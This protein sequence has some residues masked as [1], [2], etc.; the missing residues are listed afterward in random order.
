MRELVLHQTQVHLE[1]HIRR[2]D[3]LSHLA[4]SP[5][6]SASN[7]SSSGGGCGLAHL[8]LQPLGR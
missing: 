2:P 1:G 4:H 8:G 6:V 3:G 5:L 7:N